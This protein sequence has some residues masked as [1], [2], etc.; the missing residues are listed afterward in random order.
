M[1][2]KNDYEIKISFAGRNSEIPCHRDFIECSY[3][4]WISE[5]VCVYWKLAINNR[6]GNIK[7]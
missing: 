5:N 7:V 4:I 1:I 6:E 2:Y 3:N